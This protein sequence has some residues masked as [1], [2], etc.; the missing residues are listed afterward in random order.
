MKAN[1][2]DEPRVFSVKGH[3]I[4]DFGKIILDQDEMISFQT[5]SGK[6]FDFTA[7]EWGFY[8]TPSLNSRLKNVGFKTALVLNES[9]QV[10]VMAVE[11]DKIDLFKSY[12]KENQNSRII[13]WLDQFF[14]D[15]Q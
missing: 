13:C 14:E 12:L 6:E 10:Y 9:N 5:N 7:K 3:T 11:K 4:K 1:L 2:K 15:E 8:A